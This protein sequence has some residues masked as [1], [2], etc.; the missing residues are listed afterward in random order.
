MYDWEGYESWGLTCE[1]C[2]GCI[3]PCWGA[4]EASASEFKYI[5]FAGRLPGVYISE[6]RS[7]P[8]AGR[9]P[10][11]YTSEFRS[12][13]FAGRLPGVYISEFIHIPFAR[14]LPGVYISERGCIPF[15]GTPG[16]KGSLHTLGATG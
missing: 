10:G 16:V 11:V 15:W 6:F 8:F 5:P 7:I 2:C 13:P 9:L 1:L 14:R 4:T 12:I 3:F